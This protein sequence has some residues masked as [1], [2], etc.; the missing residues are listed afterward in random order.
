MH[1]F[2]QQVRRDMLRPQ[3]LDFAHGTTGAEVDPDHIAVLR[4]KIEHLQGDEI[5]E[6]VEALGADK[7]LEEMGA[8]IEELA[9]LQLEDPEA[10]ERF[11][12][13]QIA[14]QVNSIL[15]TKD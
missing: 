15:S 6:K 2:G 11:K 14:A 4:A 1:R 5:R 10:F 8:N 3:G 7:A 12:E 13:S 9:Q